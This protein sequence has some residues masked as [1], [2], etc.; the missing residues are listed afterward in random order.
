MTISNE[1]VEERQNSGYGPHKDPRDCSNNI[2]S[3]LWEQGECWDESFEDLAGETGLTRDQVSHVLV[4]LVQGLY[5][6]S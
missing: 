5:E 1:V 4:R 6:T 2:F 3:F